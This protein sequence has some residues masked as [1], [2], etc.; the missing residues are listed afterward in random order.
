MESASHSK[1]LPSIFRR[2][3]IW[4][5]LVMAVYLLI[6]PLIVTHYGATWDEPVRFDYA[7]RSL[8]VYATGTM[9]DLTD[10]KGPFFIMLAYL[11]AYGLNRI[12]PGLA[13]ID[14]WHFITYLSFLLGVYF[15][16]RLCRRW[17]EPAPAMAA[18]LLFSTQPVIWGHAFMNPKDM[19]FMSFFIASA[20]LGLE[21][22][23]RFQP[24]P[25]KVQE[26]LDLLRVEPGHRGGFFRKQWTRLGE[27]L[28]RQATNWRIAPQ[29]VRRLM[30]WM[31]AILVGSIL[32]FPL[33][34]AG[35]AQVITM[36]YKAP[37][38]SRLGELFTHIAQNSSRIPV[39]AY[40]RKGQ[41][42]TTWIAAAFWSLLGLAII[43][44]NQMPSASPELI[45]RFRNAQ[46]ALRSGVSSFLWNI[47]YDWKGSP[48]IARIAMTGLIALELAFINLKNP[49]SI[50][51]NIMGRIALLVA[52]VFAASRV[53][54]SSIGRWAAYLLE[55]PV[56]LAGVFLGFASDIRTIGPMSGV[57]VALYLL[58]KGRHKSILVVLAYLAVGALVTYVFW[59]YLWHSPLGHYYSSL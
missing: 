2:P 4:I 3:D 42:I 17:I 41:T 43:V 44:A 52:I 35:L 39:D 28:S 26:E 38:S 34:Q 47:L 37:T 51:A 6:G 1:P 49:L 9:G 29:S 10:E 32:I 48:L 11:G 30:I 22:A 13:V 7:E 53:F 33:A 20:A 36:A 46:A 31:A 58:V 14:G 16:Y 5:W 18:T 54:P 24:R 8:N 55:P 15:F 27:I 21:M 59:P 25:A 56:L 40:I 19:P 45:E 23:E 57:L 50:T 12:F